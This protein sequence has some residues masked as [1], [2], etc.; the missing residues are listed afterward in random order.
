ML[1]SISV[2]QPILTVMVRKKSS[3]KEDFSY[4]MIKCDNDSESYDIPITSES[5]EENFLFE[6]GKSHSRSI[7]NE[8]LLKRNSNN[9]LPKSTSVFIKSKIKK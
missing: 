5:H 1:Y 3:S 6:S 4:I 9:E 2:K 8:Y 7:V